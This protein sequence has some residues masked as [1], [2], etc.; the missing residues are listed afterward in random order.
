MTDPCFLPYI[1]VSFEGITTTMNLFN[2]APHLLLTHQNNMNLF[3]SNAKLNNPT[4]N[5]DPGCFI[6]LGDEKSA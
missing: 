4:S 6:E 1:T 2:N 5:I 3:G